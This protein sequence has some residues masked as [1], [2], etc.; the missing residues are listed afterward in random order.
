MV[1]P[2]TVEERDVD[3][4][5]RD[6]KETFFNSN[7]YFYGREICFILA[8]LITSYAALQ[9]APPKISKSPS[10]V[11]FF[12]RTSLVADFYHGQLGP[13]FERVAES[14]VSFLMYYAPWDAESQATRMQFKI[15]AQYYYKQVYF[16]AINCWQPHSECRQQFSRVQQFPVLIVYTQQNK[17]IQY[18]GIRE[19]AHMIRFLQY[20]LHP[21]ERITKPAD[22]L[23]LMSVYDAVVVGCFNFAG[24]ASSPGYYSFYTTAL[25]FLERDPH[26]E[27]GFAVITDME[28]GAQMGIDCTPTLRIYMWNETLQYSHQAEFTPDVLV[29]WIFENTHLISVWVTPPGVKSLTLAPYVEEGS[30]LILFTPRNPLQDG[31]YNYNMLR[32]VGLEYYNCDLNPWVSNLAKHLASERAEMKKKYSEIETECLFW[33]DHRRSEEDALPVHV[34]GEQWRNGSYHSG[35]TRRKLYR[36]CERH[37]AQLQGDV[38]DDD[39]HLHENDL[40]MPRKCKKEEIASCSS[41]LDYGPFTESQHKYYIC[42]KH[43]N[44]ISFHT[45]ML[46]GIG[47]ERSSDALQE[48]ASIERCRRLHRAKHIHHPVFPHSAY[49]RKSPRHFT[50]LACNTNKTMSLIAMD[51]LQFHQFAAGLGIDVLARHDKTAVVIFNVVQESS[52]ILDTEF[53]KGAMLEF[54]KNYT[55]GLL[56]RSLRS[57]SILS[58]GALN[59]YPEQDMEDCWKKGV[60]CVPELNSNSFHHIVMAQNVSVV[61]LYHSSYCTFCHRVSHIY[62]TVARYFRA[63]RHLTFTRIDGES[64]DLPWEFTM[65]HYPTIL[66][67]PAHR[68]SES[69]V[70]PRHHPITVTNL[71][72][73][74]LANLDLE[75]RSLWGMIG[76]CAGWGRQQDADSARDCI[77]RVRRES[78]TA[79]ANSLKQYKSIKMR[80]HVF[81]LSS[82]LDPSQLRLYRTSTHRQLKHN[83]YR[84]QHLKEV[85]LILGSVDRLQEDTIE[86]VAIQEI[87]ERYR[88]SL[89]K[90]YFYESSD[91]VVPHMKRSVSDI[92]ST[93]DEL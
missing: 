85:N 60:V 39:A 70:F 86:Y 33:K 2:V 58:G 74:V 6:A 1:M 68:K 17:G 42:C 32:E 12:P 83:V 14:D 84:L 36:I 27:I 65:H 78:L 69:H 24:I 19:A 45:S 31:N 71:V 93:R 66:F 82:S 59:H 76:L 29:K 11:P 30:V 44:S 15:V 50:G 46:T 20:V 80:W 9:N 21:L 41:H 52:Y 13:A 3:R 62:L 81:K 72:N 56:N 67:S 47:D 22:V 51:S 53:S 88:N 48:A 54:I 43:S 77:A 25:K 91:V 5:R 55:D 7:M 90:L 23:R 8:L 57:S 49:H 87:Y 18:K 26:R 28:T 64:N 16:A 73:F 63:V 35:Q 10:P 34:V 75:E 61:L 40:N 89:R 38:D 37:N 4:S 79:I 92:M